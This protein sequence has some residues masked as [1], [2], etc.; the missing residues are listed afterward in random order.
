MKND[1]EFDAEAEVALLKA[2]TKSRKK[3]RY[4]QRKSKLFKFNFEIK[5]LR[6]SGASFSEIQ[7]WLLTNKR[8]KVSRTTINRF[9]NNAVI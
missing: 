6:E 4:T 5:K 2:E 1:E 8:L 7:R 3:R 9:F